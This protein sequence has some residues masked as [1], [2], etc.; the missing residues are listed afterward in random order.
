MGK[1]CQSQ[2]YYEVKSTVNITVIVHNWPVSSTTVDGSRIRRRW[3]RWRCS[4]A[5]KSRLDSRHVVDDTTRLYI[6][7]PLA[8]SRCPRPD[9]IQDRCTG[10]SPTR[11]N[12]K[13]LSFFFCS[14]GTNNEWRRYKQEVN[15]DDSTTVHRSATT[16]P[17]PSYKMEKL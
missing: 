4:L 8:N 11:R 16:R 1:D 9:H 5:H 7:R 15:Y 12:H 2:T 17:Q 3:L 6:R 13:N 10:R 14:D